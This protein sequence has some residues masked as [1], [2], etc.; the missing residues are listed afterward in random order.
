MWPKKVQLK[1]ILWVVWRNTVAPIF[2]ATHFGRFSAALMISSWWSFDDDDY[3]YHKSII[4]LPWR[5]ICKNEETSENIMNVLCDWFNKET[6]A[7][8]SPFSGN[9]MAIQRWYECNL[10]IIWQYGN[11]MAIWQYCE[12][13]VEE[14]DCGNAPSAPSPL[15]VSTLQANRTE[16]EGKGSLLLILGGSPLS[17]PIFQRKDVG[18]IILLTN[19]MRSAFLSRRKYQCHRRNLRGSQH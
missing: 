2:T 13:S 15:S 8:P 9:I 16:G 4:L 17:L 5:T 18:I 7:M 3:L 11:I 14:R 10:A 12:G 19:N 1:L 6:V